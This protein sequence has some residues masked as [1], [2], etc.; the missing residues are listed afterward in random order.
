MEKL[1][2]I[3]LKD[4]MV[5]KPYTIDIN[6]PFSK[7]WEAFKIYDIRHLPVIDSKGILRGI[8]TQRDL[9]RIVSPHITTES[10]LVYDKMDLDR[11]ILKHV[12]T[13]EVITLSPNS[14]LRNAIDLMTVAKYGCIPIVDDN[15]YLLGII[16]QIDILK[17][18]T[19]YFI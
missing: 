14:T 12:M 19:E 11:Y 8:V 13:K 7:V 6:E 17:A 1:Y 4:I 3:F 16:T 2:K 5:K 10:N 18:V 9:Y 15:K